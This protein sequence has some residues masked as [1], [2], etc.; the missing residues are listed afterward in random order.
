MLLKT[1]QRPFVQL[2]LHSA[3][4]APHT[5]AGVKRCP[6]HLWPSVKGHDFKSFL[7]LV[8]S[9]NQVEATNSTAF[10]SRKTCLRESAASR[11]VAETNPL[12]SC[13][14]LPLQ[15]HRYN[16]TFLSV[17]SPRHHQSSQNLRCDSLEMCFRW[18]VSQWKLTTEVLDVN[19]SQSRPA[20]FSFTF[21]FSLERCHC[22]LLGGGGLNY[23]TPFEEG[24][25][26]QY[27]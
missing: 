26:K 24:G 12:W 5:L 19:E 22:M 16:E 21:S 8:S 6:T 23:C 20:P 10:L 14:Q 7:S 25:F 13:S 3:A 27:F 1:C 15:P 18:P 9:Y 11:E 17:P 2:S 4:D